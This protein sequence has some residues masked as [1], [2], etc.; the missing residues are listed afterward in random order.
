MECDVGMNRKLILLSF[1]L[2]VGSSVSTG[3]ALAGSGVHIIVNHRVLSPSVSPQMV[4]GRVVA[5]VRD[6]AEV[7]GATVTW[8]DQTQTVRL[9]APQS[10]ASNRRI[11]LLEQ[12]LAPDTAEQAVQTW[13][14]GVQTRNGALQYAVLAPALREQRK[15]EFEQ[16]GWVTGVSSPWVKEFRID[17][18]T[19]NA[20]GTR[21]FPVQFDWRTSVDIQNPVDWS[22]IPS[23]PVTVQQVDQHWYVVNAPR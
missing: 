20:D 10:D 23:I 4:D 12:A 1:T 18:G 7:L 16:V 9:D 3:A 15:A 11:A 2:F 21:T 14:R 13:A 5:P 19:Q 17:Q 22:K 6:V 8:D